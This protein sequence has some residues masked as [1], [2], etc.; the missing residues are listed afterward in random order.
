MCDPDIDPI[1]WPMPM[2]LEDC[3][4]GEVHPKS[5]APE[6]EGVMWDF[7]METCV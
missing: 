5:S 7:L 6:E 3:P 2:T 4:L 1:L